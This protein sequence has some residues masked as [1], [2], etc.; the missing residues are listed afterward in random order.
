[1]FYILACTDVHRLI[2]KVPSQTLLYAGTFFSIWSI[3]RCIIVTNL[4]EAMQPNLCLWVVQFG[5]YRGNVESALQGLA[6]QGR[7]C[8][9]QPYYTFLAFANA[10]LQQVVPCERWC[11]EIT[12]RPNM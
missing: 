5:R 3:T 8:L 1:M 12:L 2:I 4:F 7:W 10:S 9:F 11:S 6:R